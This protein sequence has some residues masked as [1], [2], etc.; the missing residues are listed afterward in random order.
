MIVHR[1]SPKV[2]L[3]LLTPEDAEDLWIIRRIITPGDL[4]SGETS[5]VVK[6]VGDYVRPNK[7][8]RVKVS[9]TLRVEK[10]ALDSSLER[11]RISGGIV[12]ASDEYVSRG[13]SHSLTVT[14]GRRL[15]LKKN[16]WSRLDIDL[17]K[18]GQ[19]GGEGFIL[20]AIDRR[21]AGIGLVKGVHLQ[22]LPTVHSG[23]SGK[24]YRE[25][26]VRPSRFFKEVE[27]A[28][29]SIFKPGRRVYILGPGAV[30]NMFHNY[31]SEHSSPLS[32]STT[33]IEGV[34][35]SGEDGVYLA[36][37]S[38][39]LRKDL[40]ESRIGLAASLL[41]EAMRRIS[42]GDDRVALALPDV[43]KASEA[44]AVD[45]LLLS[46]RIFESRVDE[47][48][49]IDLLNRVE[50]FKGKVI[51]VDTST[52]LGVQVSTLGGVVA[53]LRYPLHIG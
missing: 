9:V 17:I 41:E 30:K 53:L 46:D 35:S 12:S 32:D 43:L 3:A 51:L 31:L 2:G 25:S 11:L 19:S 26:Q 16:M 40:E 10:A 6:A 13:S 20:I 18:R 14:P 23:F 34:D 37:H 29:L 5:R 38:K 44:G 33:L 39:S 15:G 49:I 50:S 28:A 36:L 4:V 8:E 42:V 21:E 48:C 24:L 52:D 47:E 45:S 22:I 1:F 7:G 27:E